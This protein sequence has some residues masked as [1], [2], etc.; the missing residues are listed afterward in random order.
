MT[1]KLII[2][3]IILLIG[4]SLGAYFTRLHYLSTISDLESDKLALN[5]TIETFKK[6]GDRLKKENEEYLEK[7]AKPIEPIPPD[8]IEKV[9]KIYIDRPVVVYKEGECKLTQN[10]I[11]A[12]N[13]YIHLTK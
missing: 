2:A 7:L 13:E 4:C 8:V 10:F 3:I 1:D 11:D 9:R 6:E 12:Y 5:T